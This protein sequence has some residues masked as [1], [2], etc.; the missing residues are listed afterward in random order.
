LL[1]FEN[2]LTI[3]G[4][5]P[6]PRV[7]AD[8]VTIVHAL[9]GWCLFGLRSLDDQV[10]PLREAAFHGHDGLFLFW[11]GVFYHASEVC[12]FSTVP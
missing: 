5:N 10:W 4:S 1:V 12:F 3:S 6:T 8:A 9:S 7:F 2:D 11:N